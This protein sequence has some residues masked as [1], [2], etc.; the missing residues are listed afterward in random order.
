MQV[1]VEQAEAT[2]SELHVVH[3]GRL[4]NFLM[5]DPDVVGHDCELYVE[6]E[7]ES[8]E[9]LRRVAWQ[10][11]VAGG[12]VAAAHLRMG[13]PGREI[14]RLGEEIGAGVIVVG[15][16]GRGRLRRAIAGSVSDSVVR[17]ARCPVLVVSPGA[18]R[19]SSMGRF[20]AAG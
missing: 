15:S 7:R 1:A 6:L 11:K 17:H 5:Q 10:L 16:R 9:R 18:P 8:R 13:W 2:G 20:E 12:T 4:P 19:G 3:V 14:A